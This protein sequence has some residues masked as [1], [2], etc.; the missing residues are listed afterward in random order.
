MKLFENKPRKFQGPADENET[1]YNYYDRSARKDIGNVRELLESWFENLP[2]NEKNETKER[3]KKNFDSVFYELFLYNFFL[4]LGFE[5][6][7]HPIIK[8]TKKRPDFLIKKDNLEIYVEAKISEAKSEVEKSFDNLIRRFYDKISKIKSDH[9]IFHIEELTIKT[10]NQPSTKELKAKILEKLATLNH[11]TELEKAKTKNFDNFQKIN[12]ENNEIN[13]S[14]TFLPVNVDAI[15]NARRSVGITPI[16]T[17]IGGAE[18]AIR[19]SIRKKSKRYGKLD[20][21]YLICVNALSIKSSSLHDIESAI[22]GSLA[23]SFSTNP[24]NTN[25]KFIRNA[26][27]IF[28]NNGAKRI[29]NVSGVMVNRIFPNNIPE[30]KYWIFAHPFTEN[31]LDFK[32]LGLPYCYVKESQVINNECQNLREIF[33]LPINWLNN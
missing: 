22:W 28:Y 13:I 25:G 32:Q 9:F 23:I 12:Y 1:I 19:E 26:D 11:N 21:P 29:R 18:E 16:E 17:F 31:S 27:G 3:F 15:G 30:S 24:E 2:N 5:I 4:K 20:K 14:I 33:E 6:I 10:T 7:I 8:N